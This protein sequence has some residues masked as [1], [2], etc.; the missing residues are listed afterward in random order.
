MEVST[1]E[2]ASVVLM[3]ELAFVGIMIKGF[4]PIEANGALTKTCRQ[5]ADGIHFPWYLITDANPF[6]RKWENGNI[7]PHLL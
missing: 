6:D 2:F 7:D 5:R 4:K 3:V 1:I